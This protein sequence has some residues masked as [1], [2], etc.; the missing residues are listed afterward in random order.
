MMK[1]CQYPHKG[2]PHTQ[3]KSQ[4]AAVSV[5]DAIII[6]KSLNLC[7]M[8]CYIF[9]TAPLLV[10]SFHTKIFVKVSNMEKK[11]C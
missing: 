2:K 9:L 11:G 1:N 7:G 6:I 8:H 3:D 5:E 10:L 4:G